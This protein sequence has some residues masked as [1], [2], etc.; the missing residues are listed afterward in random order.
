M[1]KVQLSEATTMSPVTDDQRFPHG[2]T[3]QPDSDF[4][5]A[6]AGRVRETV[7][8]DHGR[9]ADEAT[10]CTYDGRPATHT[11]TGKQ[12]TPYGLC[13][14]CDEV[15]TAMVAADV[16][17]RWT[18]TTE[19]G[20]TV[21]GYLPAWD[22]GDPSAHNIPADRLEVYVS[23]V[24]HVQHWP[25]QMLASAN[26]SSGKGRYVGQCPILCPQMNLRPFDPN[27]AERIPNVS[28]ELVEGSDD[29]IEHLDPAGVATFAEQLRA[30]ADR[31]ENEVLPAL[32]AA[33]ADWAA[34]G[35]Q[36]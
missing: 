6:F 27:T 11:R 10:V 2:A 26:L 7:A 1:T 14:D 30:Q 12:G 9:T 4:Y 33:R 20:V 24:D 16:A 3:S 34:N 17:R 19:H 18:I 23:D 8:P 21:S 25:G 35:G 13:A 28:V 15:T 29:W 5:R 22:Q 31:L 32:V 36:K